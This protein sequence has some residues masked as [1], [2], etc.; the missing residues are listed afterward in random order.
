M[1]DRTTKIFYLTDEAISKL[2][3]SV[4]FSG[5]TE[6]SQGM[7]EEFLQ[8]ALGGMNRV[9]KKLLDARLNSARDLLSH[10][11]QATL[12][13]QLKAEIEALLSIEMP[14]H[15]PKLT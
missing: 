4:P 13:P 12:W 9:G 8:T 5:M 6:N 10:E 2:R 15:T 7:L 14:V 3:S 1:A 11:H